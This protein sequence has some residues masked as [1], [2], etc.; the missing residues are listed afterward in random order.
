MTHL[1]NSKYFPFFVWSEE[2]MK[3]EWGDKSNKNYYAFDP[4]LN[5]EI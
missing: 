2:E 1:S 3:G 5:I 4:A